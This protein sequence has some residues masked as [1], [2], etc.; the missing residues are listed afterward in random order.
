MNTQLPNII[1]KNDILKRMFETLAGED[2]TNRQYVQLVKEFSSGVDAPVEP[3]A[4]KLVGEVGVI[5]ILEGVVIEEI[6]FS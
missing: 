1:M 6:V 5:Y 4:V 3:D 2:L